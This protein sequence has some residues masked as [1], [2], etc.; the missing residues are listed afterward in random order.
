MIGA[1]LFLRIL[2]GQRPVA[3]FPFP[4]SVRSLDGSAIELSPYRGKAVLVNSPQFDQSE[5]L[6]LRVSN[7]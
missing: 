4:I 7:S 2:S 3:R 5:S 6:N 1:T